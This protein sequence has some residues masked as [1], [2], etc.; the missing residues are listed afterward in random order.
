MC[1][2]DELGVV[3][4]LVDVHFDLVCTLEIAV[5]FVT[6]LNRIRAPFSG[7]IALDMLL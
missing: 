4:F 1:A 7:M 2:R 6:L 3:N 5:F